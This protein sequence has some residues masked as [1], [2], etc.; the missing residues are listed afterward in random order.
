VNRAVR[1][2]LT[3]LVATV[4]IGYGNSLSGA[5]ATTS[6]SSEFCTALKPVVQDEQR[7]PR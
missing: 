3:T 4:L 2:S 5:A 1:Y 6:R 7:F